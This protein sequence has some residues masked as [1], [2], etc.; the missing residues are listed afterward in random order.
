MD[1]WEK[2]DNIVTLVWWMANVDDAPA[3]EIA[4][5]VEKPWKF[6]EEWQQAKE[7]QS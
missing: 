6:E 3:T 2:M 4:Y 7:Y 5:A 1:W